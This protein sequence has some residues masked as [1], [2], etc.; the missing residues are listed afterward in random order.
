MPVAGDTVVAGGV[1]IVD[2]GAIGAA[3]NDPPPPPEAR[4]AKKIAPT[5]PA[6][7]IALPPIF[8]KGSVRLVVRELVA[9]E[10]IGA[11]TFGRSGS[12]GPASRGR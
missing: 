1:T 10:L 6:P 8:G 4:C 9:G 12:G 11:G 5:M 3:K 2:P 7:R